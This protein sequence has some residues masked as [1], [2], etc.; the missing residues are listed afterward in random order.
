MFP[1]WMSL[2]GDPALAFGRPKFPVMLPV[3]RSCGLILDKLE[4]VIWL[5]QWGKYDSC[6]LGY[7]V[8]SDDVSEQHHMRLVGVHK[9]T[10]LPLPSIEFPS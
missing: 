9:G 3:V 2:S 4:L 10:I 6:V 7:V 5:L 8:K 1:D